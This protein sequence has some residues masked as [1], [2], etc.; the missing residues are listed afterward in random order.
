MKG[1]Y[2]VVI[3]AV[4]AA[5][6]IGV[7]VQRAKSHGLE[8]VVVDDGSRDRTAA[9]ASAEGA[10][11]ISHLQNEGKG[12]ALRTG[13]EHAL[14]ARY[15]GVVTMDGDGQ[16][17]PAEIPH[18]ISAAE[19]Q[20]AAVVLG[21]RFVNGAA[22]PLARRITN[23]AMS[24]LI[25]LLIR[26]AVPDSQCGFRF[27]RKEVLETVPLRSR[28]YEIETELLVGAA[29]RRWKIVS[30]PVQSIYHPDRKSRIQPLRDAARF[31]SV[32]FRAV[33]RRR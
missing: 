6:T 23:R 28:L 24:G 8:V 18:L 25:S 33:V 13:F 21:N 19:H 30:V 3:P 4:D 15:D 7:L 9:A 17:D 32:L 2:C 29:R 11:V 22:M 1:R 31:A 14:R 5:E 10:L 27:I 12:R 20:H 26:Q 16:H